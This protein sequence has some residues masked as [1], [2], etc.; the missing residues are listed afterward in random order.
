MLFLFP[1][2]SHTRLEESQGIINSIRLSKYYQFEEKH[3]KDYIKKLKKRV[4]I[5]LAFFILPVLLFT[6]SIIF[7]FL[8]ER[9]IYF[10]NSIAA[11][12]GMW[13]MMSMT[14]ITSIELNLYK[15][16]LKSCYDKIRKELERKKYEANSFKLIETLKK[17]SVLHSSVISNFKLFN[18]FLKF[19]IVVIIVSK[20]IVLII[21][22]F[23]LV[24][25]IID[26]MLNK[27]NYKI[28]IFVIWI[29]LNIFQGIII[30]KYF[31]NIKYWVSQNFKMKPYKINHKLKSKKV[32]FL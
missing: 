29:F 12:I 26:G 10:F 11:S 30:L 15:M 1:L 27:A 25:L 7:I 21:L 19:P 9:N 4:K 13:I 20:M 31:E 8:K 14:F 22:F 32:A 17:A 5:H 6:G 28:I 18:E 2:K 23:L 16:I 24:Q 3:W